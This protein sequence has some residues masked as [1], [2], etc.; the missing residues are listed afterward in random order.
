MTEYKA[1]STDSKN[2]TLTNNE[3]VIGKLNYKDWFS[4]AASICLT[5]NSIFQIEP[6]GFWGTTIE[7]KGEANIL[8]KLKMNWNGDI[9]IHTNFDNNE[10]DFVFKHISNS[11]ETI[12]VLG[13]KE[14]Q[15]LL[16][17]KPKG[18]WSEMN[19]E[20]K[21][22]ASD[23]FDGFNPKEILLLLAVHCANYNMVGTTATIIGGTT[24]FS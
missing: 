24:Y 5:D 13:D 4:F 19:Y 16:T 3:N 10:K 23:N 22:T 20:Y 11:N 7:L 2:L 14:H 15:E 12:F 6:K 17:I 18:T 8:A 1:K 9:I 21:I